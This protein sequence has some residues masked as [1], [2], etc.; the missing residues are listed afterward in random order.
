MITRLPDTAPIKIIAAIVN[1]NSRTVF[2]SGLFTRSR[3]D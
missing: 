3:M 2:A 1:G